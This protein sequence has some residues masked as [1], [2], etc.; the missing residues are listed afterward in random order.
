MPWKK[1]E[2]F[3]NPRWSAQTSMVNSAQKAKNARGIPQSPMTVRYPLTS[4]R[5]E[6]CPWERGWYHRQYWVPQ[7]SPSSWVPMAHLSRII[8]EALYQMTSRFP[9]EASWRSPTARIRWKPEGV[10][11]TSSTKG[12]SSGSNSRH[13]LRA[14]SATAT[15]R[16]TS[17]PREYVSSMASR[18][19]STRKYP[20]IAAQSHFRPC[21]RLRKMPRIPN[22]TKAAKSR[23][24]AVTLGEAPKSWRRSWS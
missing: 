11:A 18:R 23:I 22:I 5:R 10:R 14:N 6:L 17:P 13:C 24:G 19:Q 20:G 2:P 3:R 21:R 7:G 15:A 12:T 8:P 1:T 4:P 9:T 16:E